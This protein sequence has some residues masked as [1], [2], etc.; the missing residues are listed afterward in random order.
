MYETCQYYSCLNSQAANFLELRDPS[1][2]EVTQA[3]DG[4]SPEDLLA[5]GRLLGCSQ[6][7]LDGCCTDIDDQAICGVEFAENRGET[8]RCK[9]RGCGLEN[10][11]TG[12]AFVNYSAAAVGNGDD[13]DAVCTTDSDILTSGQCADIRAVNWDPFAMPLRANNGKACDFRMPCTVQMLEKGLATA[14]NGE[15]YTCHVFNNDASLRTKVPTLRQCYLTDKVLNEYDEMHPGANLRENA[16]YAREGTINELTNAWDVLGCDVNQSLNTCSDLYRNLKDAPE[17]PQLRSSMTAEDSTCNAGQYRAMRSCYDD[18]AAV[19]HDTAPAW[20]TVTANMT[21]NSTHRF[22]SEDL[23]AVERACPLRTEYLQVCSPT[24]TKFVH[25]KDPS[26]LNLV[27]IDNYDLLAN[28]HLAGDPSSVSAWEHYNM[29]PSYLQRDSACVPGTGIQCNPHDD[30]TCVAEPGYTNVGTCKAR[31]AD[32]AARKKY[33]EACTVDDQGRDPCEKGLTC[34]YDYGSAGDSRCRYNHIDRGGDDDTVCTTSADCHESL[35]C[36]T[37][38]QCALPN[39]HPVPLSQAGAACVIDPMSVDGPFCNPHTLYCGYDPE[40]TPE[41]RFDQGPTCRPRSEVPVETT[42]GITAGDNQFCTTDMD[43]AEAACVGGECRRVYTNPCEDDGQC[44][45]GTFCMPPTSDAHRNAVIEANE[46]LLDGQHY[47]L[48][49]TKFGNAEGGACRTDRDCTVG[50]RCSTDEIPT[51]FGLDS[52]APPG[53][54]PMLERKFGV[55]ANVAKIRSDDAEN[56]RIVKLVAGAFVG[57]LAAAG[58]YKYR[59]DML[60]L[61]GESLPGE[62]EGVDSTAFKYRQKYIEDKIKS[63]EF[64]EFGAHVLDAD[65]YTLQARGD[66]YVAPAPMPEAER[67]K[68]YEQQHEDELKNAALRAI[69]ADGDGSNRIETRYLGSP[70][71]PVLYPNARYEMADAEHPHGTT[72]TTEHAKIYYISEDSDQFKNIKTR[73]ATQRVRAQQNLWSRKLAINRELNKLFVQTRN[74]V[75]IAQFLRHTDR[76]PVPTV[77]DTEGKVKT[78]LTTR[79]G[80]ARTMAIDE[81]A[82]YARTA[83][84]PEGELPNELLKSDLINYVAKQ[85]EVTNDQGVY[86]SLGVEIDGTRYLDPDAV[87]RMINKLGTAPLLSTQKTL[88]GQAV[89]QLTQL[90]GQLVAKRASAANAASGQ[91]AALEG[92]KHAQGRHQIVDSRLNPLTASVQE[93]GAMSSG[94]RSPD[95]IDAVA[96]MMTDEFMEPQTDNEGDERKWKPFRSVT[97]DT[98][99]AMRAAYRNAGDDEKAKRKVLQN[100][101]DTF[102]NQ[103]GLS[104]D[105]IGETLHDKWRQGIM[106]ELENHAK[107]DAQYG[108]SPLIYTS[109]NSA[110]AVALPGKVHSLLK[111]HG[112][113]IESVLPDGGGGLDTITRAVRGAVDAVDKGRAVMMDAMLAERGHSADEMEES[114]QRSLGL[115]GH[116]KAEPSLPCMRVTQNSCLDAEPKGEVP[117]GA[118]DDE[119]HSALVEAASRWANEADVQT[120]R[121]AL[122]GAENLYEIALRE[123]D[124]VPGFETRLSDTSMETTG[125]PRRV[126]TQ[127]INA[128]FTIACCAEQ[129]IAAGTRGEQFAVSDQKMADGDILKAARGIFHDARAEE[130]SAWKANNGK[131]AAKTCDT[132]VDCMDVGEFESFVRELKTTRAKRSATPFLDKVANLDE[133]SDASARNYDQWRKYMY[134]RKSAVDKLKELSGGD[135][136]ETE[137]AE[138]AR[139]YQDLIDAVNGKDGLKDAIQ[140]AKPILTVFDPLQDVVVDAR[141][142]RNFRTLVADD[143]MRQVEVE[144]EVGRRRAAAQPDQAD[145]VEALVRQQMHEDSVLRDRA[146]MTRVQ[147]NGLVGFRLP[148]DETFMTEAYKLAQ[149]RG[150]ASRQMDAQNQADTVHR[151]DLLES[152]DLAKMME[153]NVVAVTRGAM[154]VA[155]GHRLFMRDDTAAGTLDLLPRDMGDVTSTIQNALDPTYE[156]GSAPEIDMGAE[157]VYDALAG[158][159]KFTVRNP[160]AIVTRATGNVKQTDGR[161]VGNTFGSMARFLSDASA[162]PWLSPGQRRWGTDRRATTRS[163]FLRTSDDADEFVDSGLPVALSV[164]GGGKGSYETAMNGLYRELQDSGFTSIDYTEAYAH[165]HLQSV[166]IDALGMH[167]G[168]INNMR[169]ETLADDASAMDHFQRGVA[170][171]YSHSLGIEGGDGIC[172]TTFAPPPC[173]RRHDQELENI[174]LVTA[175]Q[176]EEAGRVRS[177]AYQQRRQRLGIMDEGDVMRHIKRRE[178]VK[179]LRVKSE[180]SKSMSD[181]IQGL[182]PR[183]PSVQLIPAG[184]ATVRRGSVGRNAQVVDAS[185]DPMDARVQASLRPAAFRAEVVDAHVASFGV[186]YKPSFLRGAWS[187]PDDEPDAFGVSRDDTGHFILPDAKDDLRLHAKVLQSKNNGKPLKSEEAIRLFTMY[188]G[189]N[190]KLGTRASAVA[191]HS[192]ALPTTEDVGTSQ[193]EQY[194]ASATAAQYGLRLGSGN[195]GTWADEMQRAMSA[196][197]G[198]DNLQKLMENGETD[199]KTEAKVLEHYKTVYGDDVEVRGS[200]IEFK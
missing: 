199:D 2:A 13:D 140:R 1:G 186:K 35:V 17:W 195:A 85:L 66:G 167:A 72:R 11:E 168:N 128:N 96:Q 155:R 170:D 157:Q 14:P 67:I 40:Q 113:F 185:H 110:A 176:G 82:T 4:K 154:D 41:E 104:R 125:A 70:L 124:A 183:S 112:P 45:V 31:N 191:V 74:Q 30:L 83:L 120:L 57:A 54:D 52:E 20:Y 44:M 156:S 189:P 79:L 99:D 180:A 164:D 6:D 38:K 92:L 43:C 111:M 33:D 146:V 173:K 149:A 10:D 89:Q 150:E 108:E 198:E 80:N 65:Q 36:G 152:A 105:I 24:A 160:R 97:V 55:C 75:N 69:E 148:Y 98:V 115:W 76:T 16:Q 9:F 129:V 116:S 94:P 88:H 12:A 42:R 139:R 165:A 23:G 37:D 134:F 151:Y 126:S 131:E 109:R 64:G 86:S 32:T 63:G 77:A 127:T 163:R 122:S 100:Y 145:A 192:Y 29:T 48:R 153:R 123:S 78:Y 175:R 103:S 144:H 58:V 60:K 171:L 81:V 187:L 182:A 90:K 121:D 5:E 190:P 174:K 93:L 142:R 61:Y 196:T 73:I 197:F 159:T 28:C 135:G 194:I 136:T 172:I 158:T 25:G 62:E 51:W 177:E 15:G 114:L 132:G 179:H 91:F 143:A 68:R 49:P 178:R 47:C 87:Q 101:S 119:M 27:T 46:A 169:Y 39:D 193:F 184:A 7:D 141:G 162:P 3:A 56:T 106:I 59:S 26:K 19:V 133:G 102:M 161:A 137:F 130:L 147:A 18:L 22:A 181:G 84:V 21:K 118:L 107:R 138:N 53:L 50:L 200:F 117:G 95:E 71:L 34:K 188:A 8:G 166:A